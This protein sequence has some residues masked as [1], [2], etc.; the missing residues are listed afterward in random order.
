[1]NKKLILAFSAACLIGAAATAQDRR[2]GETYITNQWFDNW[3]VGVSGGVQAV[4]SGTKEMNKGLDFNTA[5]YRPTFE[6]TTAKWFTPIIGVRFGFQGG[7]LDEN[8]EPEILHNHAPLAD[9]WKT[10]YMHASILWNV[11]N[12]IFGYKETRFLAGV[13][14]Y[15]HGGYYRIMG[16]DV[17]YITGRKDGQWYRDREMAL[18]VGFETTFRVFPR[19]D[20]VAD[21]RGSFY[22]GRFHSD[23]GGIVLS[24]SLT[25]GV[26]YTLRK[27]FW[28]NATNIVEERDAAVASALQAKN[29]ADFARQELNRASDKILEL[30]ADLAMATFTSEVIGHEALVAR[31]DAADLV[32]KYYINSHEINFSEE[33]HLSE[34]ANDF[35]AAADGKKIH[36]TGTLD[37]LSQNVKDDTKLSYVR[38]Y[39]V[40][41]MLAGKYGVAEDSIVVNPSVAS[42]KHI[43]GALD[44]SVIIEIK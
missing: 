40:K 34:L 32:I 9:S 24:P 26:Q 8:R 1:M 12:S 38:A 25:V 33:H 30:Q 27:G 37:S 20:V 36:L 6:V 10:S 21:L 14:P 17:N 31:T 29:D 18:G 19:L 16:A 41:N 13:S 15:V 35:K 3:S 2:A 4:V 22:S 28:R 5:V 44:R 23:N 7:M 43:D 42:E 39:A 11:V